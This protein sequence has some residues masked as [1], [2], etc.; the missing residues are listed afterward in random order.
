M[1]NHT[2]EERVD[3]EIRIFRRTDGAYPVE[4]TLGG[5]QEF[6][7]GLLDAGV[8][9]WTSG[10]DP[11][12]DG[13]RLFEAFLADTPLRSAWDKARAQAPHCRIRLRID[14]T[15]A[16]LH[17]L[18]WELLT[19]G[20]ALL[21]A[22][23]ATPFSRYLPIA[24]PWS[25]AVG[26]SPLR[27][28]VVISN[29]SDLEAEYELA[30]VDVAAERELLEAAFATLDEEGQVEVEFLDAPVTLKRLEDALREEYHVL[31]FLGHGAFS[32]RR[33]QAAL[34]L[35][36][37][38]GRTHIVSD[39]ALVG[40]LARQS[41]E[42]R[43]Q[44]VT[45]MACQSASRSTSD[46]FAG[47][48]PKLVA[49]GVPAVVAMQ[50]FVAIETARTFTSTFYQRLLEH[51]S[52]DLAMNEAR[53]TL[54]TSERP[55]AAVPVLF[56]RLKSGQLWGAEADARGEMLGRLSWSTLV[57]QIQK[58]RCTSII[59]PRV[60]GSVLP[61]Q[62]ELAERWADMHTY[63]FRN[64]N[65]M[66]R[67]AQFMATNQGEDFPR[68]ELLDTLQA[69]LIARLPDELKPDDAADTLTELVQSVGWQSLVADNPNDAHRVLA[70]LDLPLYLTTNPDSFMTEALKAREREPVRE[71]CRWSEDLD[72]LDSQL[73]ENEDYEPTVEEP[74]VYHFFGSDEEAES[75]VITEDHYFNFLVR[76][77]SERDRIPYIVRDA[78]SSTSL[79][80]IGYSLYDWEF[81]VLM[82]GLVNNLTQR[83]KFKHVAVQLEL[84]DVVSTD[85][86]AVQTFLQQ[87]FQDA[88][89]N[90]YWGS[91]AQFIAELREHWEA[92]R[93]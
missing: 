53:S 88:D 65:E 15:A 79:I 68:Y 85:T 54:L 16:E 86:A 71:L 63:P 73:S 82:H 72:W 6:A 81:R 60:H 64:R 61:T 7:P 59:G 32:Q 31:H 69:D 55:D 89:I 90:V 9:P 58:G 5:Q 57:R 56:M 8:L 25:E 29:P 51:G 34:Y 87:Y 38:Q 93:K 70:D 33:E 30:P 12:Q 37:E 10:G 92:R 26:E 20:P 27:V 24:L 48:G 19:D 35:Q 14:P 66:A 52:V 67:V 76:T 17:A 4:I 45:L 47:L 46:A 84:A 41:P 28:L 13:Q 77:S 83:K 21:A 74:L 62:A 36:D 75:L 78:L 42:A 39:S 91:T 44:L 3:L 1:T 43:P 22:Q 80:F 40:M 49:V 23:A 11:A 2:D 18:P 50:D